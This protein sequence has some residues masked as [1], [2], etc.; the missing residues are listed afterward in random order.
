MPSDLIHRTATE[1]GRV[2]GIDWEMVPGFNTVLGFETIS[3]PD[4]LMNPAYVTLANMLRIPRV[5]EWRMMVWRTE[6]ARQH[7]ALDFLNVRYFLAKSG[8]PDVPG[9]KTLGRFDLTVAESETAWPRAFFTDAIAS[10]ANGEELRRLVEEG[11]GRPFAAMPSG[12]RTRPNLPPVADAA[13]AVVPARN[14]RLTNNTT[15][16]E[17]DAPTP[18]LAVLL[19]TNAPG[20]IEAFVDG[21]RAECLTVNHAFRGVRIESAGHHTVRFAYWPAV[22]TPALWLGTVGVVCLL[23]SA[24][25]LAR[26]RPAAA[27]TIP[28]HA[29]V[30]EPITTNP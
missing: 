4:P 25:L 17:I 9:T 5:W 10:Y 19:E 26:R 14:Y 20:D 27:G 30:R 12:E 16:F 6:F 15:T 11:D 3:G 28:A 2:M 24:G 8:E 1:P 21:R 29:E 13:R 18:G 22:L 7:R 23:V